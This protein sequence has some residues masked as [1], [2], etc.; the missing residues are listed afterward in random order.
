MW[1][2]CLVNCIGIPPTSNMTS[3]LSRAGSF[4]RGVWSAGLGRYSGQTCLVGECCTKVKD[5]GCLIVTQVNVDV[6]YNL[7]GLDLG[8]GP[9]VW[10]I[11]WAW[12]FS[13]PLVCLLVTVS[14]VFL[15]FTF[16]SSFLP[17]GPLLSDSF[18]GPA[19]LGEVARSAAKDTR[20]WGLRGRSLDGC[21]GH[22]HALHTL[23]YAGGRVKCG[24]GCVHILVRDR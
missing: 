18:K 10:H 7:G 24:G 8:R 17:C 6:L 3:K 5:L 1:G 19:V 11:S 22:S 13:F 2:G 16:T 9:L 23:S 20:L 12:A 15:S 14:V 21:F 4:G